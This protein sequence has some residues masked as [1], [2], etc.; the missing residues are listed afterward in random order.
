MVLKQTFTYH[1]FMKR[2][3]FCAFFLP[4]ICG[5]QKLKSNAFD[6]DSKQWRAESFSTALKATPEIKMTM[7]LRSV[8][9]SFFM[10]LTGSGVGTST[11]DVG[12]E[13]VF[14]LENDS[15]VTARS[16]SIQSIDYGTLAP[17]YRH[18]Y[19][20]YKNDLERLSRHNIKSV[21]KYSVGGFDEVLIEKKNAGNA[22]Q[23]SQLFLNELVKANPV[24]AKPALNAPAFPGGKEVF[25]RFLNKNVK[26]VY[27]LVPGEKKTA[28]VQFMV[29]ADGSLNNLQIKQSTDS[30]FDNELLRILHRMPKWKPALDNGKKVDAVVTQTV[31][32]YKTDNTLQ[33]Q[34]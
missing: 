34:L 20:I 33:V 19:M 4:L 32:F 12:T 1:Y 17:V 30:E 23:L 24:L 9:T 27:E 2:F 8:D 18:E 25:V 21:R 15:T 6:N 3:L 26:P 13:V 31:T 7:S 16:T 11:V 29:T 10:V 5:A 28:V 22:R 14:Y